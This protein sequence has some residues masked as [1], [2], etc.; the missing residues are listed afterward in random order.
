M[1]DVEK[2]QPPIPKLKKK[3][4]NQ[5]LLQSDYILPFVTFYKR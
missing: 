4:N 2:L 1:S 3:S 5:N